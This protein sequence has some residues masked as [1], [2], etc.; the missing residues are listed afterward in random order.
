MRCQCNH[1]I[2][3]HVIRASGATRCLGGPAKCDCV[4]FARR[5]DAQVHLDGRPYSKL[6]TG[7]EVERRNKEYLAIRLQQHEAELRYLTAY[8]KALNRF[9]GGY[10]A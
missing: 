10:A 9:L 1:R 3:D 2:E 6:V 8:H 5:A 4:C 7:T